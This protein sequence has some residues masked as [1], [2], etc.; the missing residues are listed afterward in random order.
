MIFLEKCRGF[1]EDARRFVFLTTETEH[2]DFNYQLIRPIFLRSLRVN[3]SNEVLKIFEQFRKNIKLGKKYKDL[4]QNEKNDMLIL[5]KKEFYDGL[6][7]DLLDNKAY[8][9][10]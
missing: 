5:K 8:T 7:K 10:A 3:T 4:N 9:L 6:L 2:L 1:E